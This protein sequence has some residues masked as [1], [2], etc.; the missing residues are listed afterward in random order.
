MKLKRIY[1]LVLTLVLTLT[2]AFAFASCSDEE[3]VITVTFYS[4]G[5]V[6]ATV[7]LENGIVALPKAP[8]KTG[9]DFIGWYYDNETFAQPF[10]NA[11]LEKEPLTENTKLYAKWEAEPE[12]H[13]HETGHHA[14]VPFTCT[15]N[16]VME[17]WTCKGC[18][19]I[20]ADENGR[21]EITLEDTVIEAH[22]VYVD[23]VGEH[24]RECSGCGRNSCDLI[25][26]L[27]GNE[28]TLLGADEYVHETLDIP[29]TYEGKPVTAIAEQAFFG[30]ESIKT[31]NIPESI[32][33][34]GAGAFMNLVNLET[35]NFGA[36]EM[37]DISEYSV[38]G[39]SLEDVADPA[40]K[41]VIK[42]NVKKIPA[43]LFIGSGAGVLEFE[44]GSVCETVGKNAFTHCAL[45]ALNLPASVKKVD[46]TSFT[47]CPLETITVAAENTAYV[48]E[49]NCL[50]VV[51]K[52][53]DESIK[54]KT[55]V[56][57]AK[58][59]QIPADTTAIGAL[60]FAFSL[61]ENVTV[62][63][64]VTSIGALAFSNCKNL[65]TVYF[66]AANYD[67][68][69]EGDKIF[70]S[71]EDYENRFTVLFG[72]G[73]KYVPEYLFE[74]AT[75]LSEY[76]FADNSVCE[77]IGEAAFYGC[78]NLQMAQIPVNVKT[79]GDNAFYGCTSLA[80]LAYNAKN[81]SD[82]VT[83]PSKTNGVFAYAGTEC[84]MG[85]FGVMIGSTVERIPANLFNPHFNRSYDPALFAV[86]F[87]EDGVLTEIGANAFLGGKALV[88]V[89]FTDTIDKWCAIEF[90]NE[91]SNPLCFAKEF[92][93]DPTSDE[94]IGIKD[95]VIPEGVTKI[96]DYA[97]IG[98]ACFETV[99]IPSTVTYIGAHAFHGANNLKSVN[100][101][102]AVTKIGAYAF[103]GCGALTSV[104]FATSD[105]W[106]AIHPEFDSN[107]KS[108]TL[109][110]ASANAALLKSDLVG[111]TWTKET[112]N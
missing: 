98:G 21:E 57:G 8:E 43:E 31:V 5:E 14:E 12:R 23:V 17:Y 72:A 89:I 84:I 110:E 54:S 7:D 27:N 37:D 100:V 80:L 71:V 33:T 56:L 75:A 73:V 70:S 52:N 79:I 25:F 62:P 86:F 106:V 94:P 109:G 38:F 92:I 74:E 4:D 99:S 47:A 1:A 83:T 101:P 88:G 41:V 48:S 30:F 16:G 49:D 103:A 15:E 111:Y 112:A 26:E 76:T 55:V 102:A 9:F 3:T 46:V 20:F 58:N 90:E 105:A 85:G 87:E 67:R 108:I 61:V 11:A 39:V 93:A 36:T 51:V 69:Y 82:L 18:E 59:S 77:K 19:E 2:C 42:N 28:Y 40:F 64:G 6:Y 96:N 60:A 45:I 29:A 35:V 95:L 104:T 63:E 32:K 22:H 66:N 68:C 34:I 65:T 107:T 44:E 78:V 24:T 53:E 91:Y 10:S 81:A 50:L 97:F 13:I